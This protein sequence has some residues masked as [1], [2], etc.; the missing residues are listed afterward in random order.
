MRDCSAGC[1]TVCI[2]YRCS[3][4]HH[5]AR[6]LPC[7]AQPVTR[8]W[9]MGPRPRSQSSSS[10][11]ARSWLC[12]TLISARCSR[13]WRSRRPGSRRRLRTAGRRVGGRP[14]PGCHRCCG[15]ASV[16]VEA[17]DRLH[18]EAKLF[19]GF[20]PDHNASRLV[21]ASADE[22]VGGVIEQLPQLRN[23]DLPHPAVTVL[24]AR[25]RRDLG[26]SRVA[27]ALTM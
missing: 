17:F 20:V 19:P 25:L 1:S 4:T 12:S 26:S 7:I 14:R 3:P 15:I 21:A 8:S 22:V 23:R 27:C 10:A 18:T 16:G 2:L 24:V 5:S 9:A 13:S 11:T 6:P